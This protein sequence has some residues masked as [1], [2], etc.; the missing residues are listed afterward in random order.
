MENSLNQLMGLPRSPLPGQHQ[1]KKAYWAENREDVG[2][3]KVGRDLKNWFSNCR[4]GYFHSGMIFKRVTDRL[5]LPLSHQ[6]VGHCW[7]RILEAY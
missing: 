3:G 6:N 7:N 2:G 5:E 1:S 4:I